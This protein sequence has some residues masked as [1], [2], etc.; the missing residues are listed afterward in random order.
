LFSRELVEFSSRVSPSRVCASHCLPREG[1]SDPGISDCSPSSGVRRNARPGAG[2]RTF[3]RKSA[4]P[5]L[6]TLQVS[7]SMMHWMRMRT[8][9]GCEGACVTIAEFTRV[10]AI[11]HHTLPKL[12]SNS[13][14]SP[15][16]PPSPVN[17]V[18][19]KDRV[20]ISA[21]V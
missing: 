12:L 8:L 14:F 9:C 20:W 2:T 6:K 10:S 1:W 5:L 16:I 3:R 19:V 4:H 21:E 11:S 18:N 13:F 7:L 17:V 15:F